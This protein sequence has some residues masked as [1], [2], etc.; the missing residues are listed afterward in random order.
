[1]LKG[2]KT[3]LLNV[4]VLVAGLTQTSGIMTIVPEQYMPYAIAAVG[5][6]NV[7]LRLVTTTAVFKTV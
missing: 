2:W 4:L 5:V 3:I 1:M 6:A 7:I